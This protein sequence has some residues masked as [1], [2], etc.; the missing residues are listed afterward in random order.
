ME[1]EREVELPAEALLEL[2]MTDA[3]KL[4]P[5]APYSDEAPEEYV[6]LCYETWAQRMHRAPLL[7]SVAWLWLAECVRARNYASLRR[8]YPL[9]D[10][11]QS[12]ELQ[13]LFLL[14]G[15]RRISLW[16][17]KACLYVWLQNALLRAEHALEA[18]SA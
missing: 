15:G 8:L 3:R 11:L 2:L 18:P 5:R 13:H 16:H 7:Y 12:A 1:A 9:C 10:R 6:A 14:V 4:A 17:L